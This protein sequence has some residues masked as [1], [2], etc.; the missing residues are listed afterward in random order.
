MAT[1]YETTATNTGGRKGHV[2]TDDQTLDLQIL[3][4]DKADGKAT[5]PE[6]LFAAGY[7]SCF[8][9]AF[10]LI[11][12]QSGFREAEPVVD[13]TVRLIDDPDH[14]S[15]KL[16]VDIHGKVKNMEQSDAEKAIQDAHDFCPYSKA[17]RGNIN[18]NLSV[19]VI[20]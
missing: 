12:K 15:P 11:L 5:N 4:P 2:Q 7:A 1:I 13:L 6:Q 16:E 8:N 19:E 3:P 18:V 10:D 9:G 20:E 17:T 14:K